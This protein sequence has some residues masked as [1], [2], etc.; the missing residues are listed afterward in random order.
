M[1]VARKKT[2][3]GGPGLRQ[4]PD[5][6]G[7]EPP[8]PSCLRGITAAATESLISFSNAAFYSGNLYTIPDRQHAI[9]DRPELMILSKRTGGANVDALLA[10]SISFHFMAH[11][12]Y[13]DRR[14][15]NE[16]AYIAQLIRH[17][18]ST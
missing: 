11:G 17:H 16:A 2:Y 13:E 10:R 1:I 3:R 8:P 18:A 4:F 15:P 14:N 9:A 7:P 6:V 5:S 12:L